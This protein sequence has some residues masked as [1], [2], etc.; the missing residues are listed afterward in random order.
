MNWNDFERLAN[1]ARRERPPTIDVREQVA[2]SIRRLS[3]EPIPTAFQ[4]M[5]IAGSS[6]A[7]AGVVAL[8]CLPLWRAET[9]ALTFL[10]ES[11]AKTLP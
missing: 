1:E 10:F 8:M 5:V 3:F 4:T 6:L 7:I 11:F 9:G 2:V